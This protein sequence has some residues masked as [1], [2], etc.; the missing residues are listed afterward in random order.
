MKVAEIPRD[1]RLYSAPSEK[2]RK[3][4]LTPSKRPT[5]RQTPELDNIVKTAVRIVAGSQPG[6]VARAARLI[7]VSEPTL[8]RWRRTGNLLQARGAEVLRVHELTG[9]PV[10]L[11]LRG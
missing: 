5:A 7:G 6:E 3:P 1:V 9:L 4:A 2:G 8:Y 10:E 11:L